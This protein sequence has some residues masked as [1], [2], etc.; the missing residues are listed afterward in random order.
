MK[1]TAARVRELFDYCPETGIFIRLMRPKQTSVRVG[2][3]AGSADQLGYL[4]IG[5]DGAVYK[6]HRLAWLYVYGEWPNGVIDH[7]NGRPSDN[8]IANLRVVD[9]RA[10]RENQRRARSDSK[11]G[12]QGAF[13]KGKKFQACIKVEGR[14]RSLGYFDTAQQAHDAYVKAKRVVHAANTL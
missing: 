10:N 1:P 11:S 2:E 6:A 5:V 13:A 14:T 7:I 3:I 4:V 12:V 8:A 9:R